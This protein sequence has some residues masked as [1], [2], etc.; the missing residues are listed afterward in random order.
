MVLQFSKSNSFRKQKGHD[1]GQRRLIV[2]RFKCDHS[3]FRETFS[4][5]LEY[6][7]GLTPM[8]PLSVSQI[9]SC[10]SFEP[11]AMTAETNGL[12][13]LLSQS[14][15]YWIF[16]QFLQGHVIHLRPKRRVIATRY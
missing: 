5:P 6:R 15:R 4:D 2:N 3:L 13:N 12:I 7:T 10:A 1:I 8:N 14:H 16:A 9:E 11:M